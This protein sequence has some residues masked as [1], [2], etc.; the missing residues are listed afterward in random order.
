MKKLRDVEHVVINQRRTGLKCARIKKGSAEQSRN[1]LELSVNSAKLSKNC[2]KSQK[3]CREVDFNFLLLRGSQNVSCNTRQMFVEIKINFNESRTS[4]FFSCTARKM[5][6]ESRD[7][8]AQ[9][10]RNFKYVSKVRRII[11]EKCDS[12]L[13]NRKINANCALKLCLFLKIVPQN[14]SEKVF[15]F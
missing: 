7:N 3:T 9:I 2:R 5:C 6:R 1:A 12:F 4:I 8:C 10:Q 15:S 13:L 11:D 14:T